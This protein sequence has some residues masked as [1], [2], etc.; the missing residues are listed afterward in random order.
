MTES[1]RLFVVEDDDDIALLIRKALQGAGHQVTR[2]RSGVDALTVLGHTTF[3]LVLLD[4]RLPD[5]PGIELLQALAREHITVPILMVTAHGDEDLATR[6]LQAGALDYI[7]KDPGLNFLTELPKRVSESVTRYRLQQMNRLLIASLENAGDGIM[8]TDLHGTILHVNRALEQ[9]TGYSRNEL[10]GQAPRLLKSGLHPDDVYAKLWRTVLARGVWQGE[11]TNRS[12]DGQLFEVSLTVSPVLDPAGQLTHLVGILRDISERKRLERQL[13]Q[14]QKMQ[15]VGTLAGGVAHE[16]NNLLAGMSGYAAL[17]LREPGVGETAREFLQNVITLSDRAAGLTR[18]LLTYARKPE[19][20][21]RATLMTEVVTATARMV[22]K[23]LCLDVTLDLEEKAHDGQPLIVVAD[24]NQLQQALI[25]L[26]LNARDAVAA[27][28][29][30]AA[31][32]NGVHE[33]PRGPVAMP[34]LRPSRPILYRLRHVEV[35]EDLRTFPQTVP[36][37]DYVVVEV[38]DH[39]C[40]MTPEVLSQAVDPFFTTKEV[41]KGTGLGLP[42]VFGIVQG[43][44]GYLTMDSAPGRGTC[45]GLYLPRLTGSPSGT[46][47]LSPFEYGQVVEPESMPRCNILVVDD[48]E[49]ILDVVGRFLEIAGHG[50]HCA[51]SGPEATEYLARG[52]EVDLVI[53]DLMM[54]GEDGL[55]TLRR[56]RQSHPDLPVLVCTGMPQSETPLPLA[57]GAAGLLRKPFR[58]NELWYAVRQALALAP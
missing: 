51:G 1:L 44:Q 12:K 34:S 37:G 45:V 29:E 4:Q 26:T 2:C 31:P 22:R 52:A 13:V 46:S 3:D 55:T 38:I 58:M 41:G 39:G 16:F 35:A 18:Q 7:V 9:M 20:L 8:V 19:L 6:V 25:N 32:D 42:V 17:A 47:S 40:G 50:V 23:T 57:A 48:E 28:E 27:L 21:R 15:S 43:H 49:A 24:A 11:L 54:P 14:A 5:L 30:C 36:P 33:G 56:L 53:L 10:I